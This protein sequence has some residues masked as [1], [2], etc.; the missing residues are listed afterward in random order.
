M[1]WPGEVKQMFQST[2]GVVDV[3]WYVEDPQVKYGLQVDLDKA[4]LHG[5]SAADVTRTLH[6][7]AWRAPRPACCTRPNRARMCLS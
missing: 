3:D 6:A 5:I 1:N 2:P 4:A 7:R